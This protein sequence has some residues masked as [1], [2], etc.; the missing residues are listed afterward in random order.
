MAEK[1]GVAGKLITAFVMLMIGAVLIGVIAGETQDRSTYLATSETQTLKTNGTDLNTSGMT[2]ATYTIAKSQTGWRTE[3]CPITSFTLKN[4]SG[5]AL[6]AGTDYTLTASTG[7]FVLLRT[8]LTKA[9]LYPANVSYQTYNYCGDDYLNS[10]WGRTVLN[11]V[12]GFFAIALMLGAVALFYS[13]GKDAGI[14]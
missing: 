10:S 2:G 5:S 4:S 11:L 7:Q 3:D 14:V 12:A 13:V 9:T 8:D 1:I 6:V